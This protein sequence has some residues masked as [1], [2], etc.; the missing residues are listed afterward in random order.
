VEAPLK[1]DFGYDVKEPE[2]VPATAKF[3]ELLAGSNFVV[4]EDFHPG[5]ENSL[6]LVDQET[7]SAITVV[8]VE[9]ATE[10]EAAS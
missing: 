4:M 9:S 2:A 3:I 6:T 10:E 5:F 8:I 1:N 7:K